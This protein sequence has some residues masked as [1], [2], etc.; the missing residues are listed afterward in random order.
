[1]APKPIP[2]ITRIFF[3]VLQVFLNN[4]LMVKTFTFYYKSDQKDNIWKQKSNCIFY[5]S[6]MTFVAFVDLNLRK[7]ESKSYVSRWYEFK[8]EA[9]ETYTHEDILEFIE[10]NSLDVLMIRK[11]I[12]MKHISIS[13]QVFYG[14]CN[15]SNIT[16]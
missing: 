12:K 2:T 1:M 7:V 15:W 16:L 6:I 10:A 4:L 5:L 8:V 11:L 3:A 14:Q 9:H 13:C